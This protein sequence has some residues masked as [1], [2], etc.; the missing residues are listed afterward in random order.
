MSKL[1]L[2]CLGAAIL[3]AACATA[4]SA[5]QSVPTVNPS[6]A[7]APIRASAKEVESHR[8]GN[9]P[10]LRLSLAQPEG[11]EL[12]M[13][14]LRVEVTVNPDGAVAFATGDRELRVALRTRAEEAVRGLKYRPFERD[15]HPVWAKFSESVGVY[16]PELK[17]SSHVPFPDIVDW[18]SVRITLERTECFGSCPSYRVELRGDGTVLY[19]GR[20]FVAI[21]GQH[22]ATVAQENVRDLVK[23]FRDADYYSLPDEYITNVT[24]SPTYLTSI[25]IDGRLKT[26]KD[27]VGLEMGMPTAVSD[28]EKSIDRLAGTERWTTGNAETV[29][30]LKHEAWNFKS[31]DAANTMARLASFGATE[32]VKE[33]VAAGA[34]L[35]GHDGGANETTLEQAAFHSDAET[36]RILLE[37][38]AGSQSAREKGAALLNAAL[39]GKVESVRILLQHGASPNSR[40]KYGRTLLMAASASGVPAVLKEVLKFQG[41]LNAHADDGRTALMDAVGAFSPDT[42]GDGLQVDRVTVVHLLLEAG[43]D[44]NAQDKNGNTA[45]LDC[46]WNAEAASLL[47]QAGANVN[48]RNKDGL[49]PLINVVTGDVTRVLLAHGADPSAHDKG[50]HTALYWANKE[51]V[52]VLNAAGVGLREPDQKSK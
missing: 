15:G 41:D 25:T 47:I 44:P 3:V 31:V 48:V 1:L 2:D 43:S 6:T 52:A 11:I 42:A 10:I 23:E 4:S 38:G 29:R 51:K 46:A 13:L 12:A 49:T 5:Q 24:D 26:V 39:A 30:S 18:K 40:D 36:V 28:L 34:P 32:A 27:Y 9:R 8:I 37:A 21:E 20:Y 14:G 50:G 45:L 35:S 19:E 22:R 17:P 7:Q 33:M 16:P